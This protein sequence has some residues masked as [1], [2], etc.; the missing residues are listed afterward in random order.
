SLTIVTGAAM[1][2]AANFALSGSLAWTPGGIGVAFGRMLQDGIVAQY[3]R[4]HC[5]K[6]NL[7][8]CPYRD[9]L[10]PTADD[11]LWGHSMFNTLGRFQ[12]L[13]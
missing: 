1:L 11:F 10:P 2:L 3:L 9:E 12:G 4:D 5:A 7:K 13:D 8:L 6:E